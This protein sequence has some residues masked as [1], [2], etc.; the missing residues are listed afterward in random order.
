MMFPWKTLQNIWSSLDISALVRVPFASVSVVPYKPV[1]ETSIAGHKRC[2]CNLVI[3]SLLATKRTPTGAVHLECDL[4]DE[5]TKSENSP[6]CSSTLAPHGRSV[7]HISY[8]T[9][10]RA[11]TFLFL[12]RAIFITLYIYITKGGRSSDLKKGGGTWTK[13]E[14]IH[15]KAVVGRMFGILVVTAALAW[16]CFELWNC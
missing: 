15:F 7:Q 2:T 12:L 4:T 1:K 6:L 8:A 10:C 5:Q 13:A 14:Q 3:K 16:V 9:I 11:S